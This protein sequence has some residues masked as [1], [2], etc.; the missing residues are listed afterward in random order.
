MRGDGGSDS[1]GRSQEFVLGG[2]ICPVL[3][4]RPRVRSAT[5]AEDARGGGPGSPTPG[6][7]VRGY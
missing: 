7:G 2:I 5:G 6:R 4:N 3:D 1:Q